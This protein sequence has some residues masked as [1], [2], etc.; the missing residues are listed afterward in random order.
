MATP[1]ERI[2]KVTYMAMTF[3]VIGKRYAFGM[4]SI[5]KTSKRTMSHSMLVFGVSVRLDGVPQIERKSR[6]FGSKV[7]S[8]NAEEL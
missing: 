7:K 2:P 5:G 3:G 6:V 8:R 1:T 4:R